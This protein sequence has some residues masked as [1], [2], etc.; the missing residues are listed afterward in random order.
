MWI[1]KFLLV[2]LVM[3]I[4]AGLALLNADPVRLDVYFTRL[5]LPLS[6]ILAGTLSLG[7]LLGGLASMGLLLGTWRRNR[8]LR[9]R[10][11]VTEQEVS[12]LR[13]LLPRDS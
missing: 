1:L 5:D 10:I 7:G 11:Q 2:L 3:L 13:T 8:R 6:L 12:R 9:R 4:G